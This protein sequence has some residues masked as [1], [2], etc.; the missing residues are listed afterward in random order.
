MCGAQGIDR[1]TSRGRYNWRALVSRA[2]VGRNSARFGAAGSLTHTKTLAY[3]G[4]LQSGAMTFA[5]LRNRG[6]VEFF[7]V[8]SCDESYNAFA[9]H[10]ITRLT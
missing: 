4:R 1:S 9:Q 2:Q 7:V 8:R 6:G 3:F 10:Q 5:P